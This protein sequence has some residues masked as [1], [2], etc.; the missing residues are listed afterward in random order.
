VSADFAT[1]NVASEQR[2]SH[3]TLALYRRLLALRRSA[4]AISRGEFRLL[5][6]QGDVVAYLRG[7]AGTGRYL[8]L[9]NIGTSAGAYAVTAADL[10]AAG[11]KG[12]RGS[13]TVVAGSH[14]RVTGPGRARRI[15]LARVALEGNEAVVIRLR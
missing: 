12:A 2:D 15:A 7:D 11:V 1:A 9:V 10:A 8:V 13:G 4:P 3:S 6:R 5:P 14:D